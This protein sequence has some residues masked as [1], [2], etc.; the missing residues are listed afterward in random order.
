M[1]AKQKT[2]LGT[3]V[4][5]ASA[6]ARWHITSMQTYGMTGSSRA[7]AAF[8]DCYIEATSLQIAKDLLLSFLL[9]LQA[10]ASKH[11]SEL[12]SK[13]LAHGSTAA[14]WLQY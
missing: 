8:E 11:Q 4:L 6:G 3:A 10:A 5:L 13:A 12:N 9:F 7:A 14:I 1:V 2:T